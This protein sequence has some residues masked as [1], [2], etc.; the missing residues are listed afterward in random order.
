MDHPNTLLSVNDMATV[1]IHQGQYD[2][3]MKSY[4]R[5]LAGYEK[6]LGVD[7][8]NTLLSVNNMATVLSTKD[9]M[10]RH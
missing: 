5:T 4:E 1:F 8:P 2:K 3:A 9:S 7:H 6:S 10:T